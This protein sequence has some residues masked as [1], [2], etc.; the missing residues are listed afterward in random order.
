MFCLHT[1][2]HHNNHY[3]QM[4]CGF[5]TKQFVPHKNRLKWHVFL[6]KLRLNIVATR[7]TRT[8]VYMR[9]CLYTNPKFLW[10]NQNS[11]CLLQY[12]IWFLCIIYIYLYKKWWQLEQLQFHEN[13]NFRKRSTIPKMDIC[14]YIEL[15]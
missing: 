6:F 3:W 8:I 4:V 9:L 2:N 13:Q 10:L 5:A 14:L 15:T 12:Q 11:R 7:K 1:T